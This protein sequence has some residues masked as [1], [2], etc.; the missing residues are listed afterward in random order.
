MF[1]TQTPSS[2]SPSTPYRQTGHFTPV[3]PSPLGQRLNIAT[4][5]WTMACDRK[6]NET[7]NSQISPV[8]F[9]TFSFQDGHSHGHSHNQ[10]TQQTQSSPIFGT[11][12]THSPFTSSL[13]APASPSPSRGKF[14]DRYASQI[15]NPMKTSSSL[16]RSKTRKM[17]MNRIKNDR[18]TGRYEARG[19]Q[20]MMMEHLA[21]KR[22]WEESMGRGLDV[23]MPTEGEIEDGDG[24]DDMLPDENDVLALDEFAAQEEAMELALRESIE[25]KI[26]FSDEDYDDIFMK[27]PDPTHDQDMDMC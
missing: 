19:E 27:L 13:H 23:A 9:P 17:F 18:D 21:D 20:M 22:R 12:S 5:P 26:S 6:F 8:A 24:D 14:A 3:R 1:A 4:P 2:P 11:T 16:A 10:S 15:A 7:T 25:N